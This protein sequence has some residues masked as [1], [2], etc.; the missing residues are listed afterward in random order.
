MPLPLL[1]RRVDEDEVVAAPAT[2]LVAKRGR[3][4]AIGDDALR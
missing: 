3:D 1:V 2:A 4:V